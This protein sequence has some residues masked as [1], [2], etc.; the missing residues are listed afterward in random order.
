MTN[1][2]T[3]I[4][5]SSTPTRRVLRTIALGLLL[6]AARIATIEHPWPVHGDELEF[7]AALGFPR[8]YPVH[9]PGYVLWIALGT[10][11]NAMGVGAYAS[12]ASLSLVASILTPM[13]LYLALR[14]VA[15]EGAAWWSALAMGLNPL[16]WFCGVTAWNYV[17]ANLV[18]AIVLV[19]AAVGWT[20]RRTP[21]VRLAAAVLA[22]GAGLRFDLLMWFG[23]LVLWT[24]GR[25]GR[26]ELIGAAAALVAGAACWMVI[27]SVLYSDA[28]APSLAYTLSVVRSTSVIDRGL[29][30]GLLRNVVKLAAYLGWGFGLGAIPIAYSLIVGFRSRTPPAIPVP[31]FVLGVGPVLAFQSLVHVTEIGHALW[32]LFPAYALLAVSCSR[33]PRRRTWIAAAVAVASAV[34]FVAYPWG[35]DVTGWRRVLNAKVAFASAAGL[36]RID[37]RGRIH[38]P[39]DFWRVPDRSTND[40]SVTAQP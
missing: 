8:P 35:T 29:V 15:G 32:Y 26:R 24:A 19:V 23:P 7:V 12:F 27:G 3:G 5:H 38:T 37:Q 4:S 20:Q 36:S 2:G 6:L 1:T 33:R 18:A 11:L 16:W 9:P 34:Q 13:L 17:A 40:T 21:A 14:C 10:L 31:L 30:D 28:N 39:N 25:V 22:V